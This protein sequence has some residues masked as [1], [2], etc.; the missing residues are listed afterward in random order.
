MKIERKRMDKGGWL[1][2]LE[3]AIAITLLIGV[4]VYMMST[5]APRKDISGDVYEKEKYILDMI[6]K[7]D[8][9][10][11]DI[12]ANKTDNI[13]FTI[14][15][16]IPVTWD[17]ETKICK[18]DDICEGSRRPVDKNVYSL[19]IVVSSNMTSY[20]PKKLRLFVWEK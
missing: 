14:Q 17:F 12:M 5:S 10:R 20:N 15:K 1:K 19:E 13:N 2:V 18:L 11:D 4:L 9:L 7:N 8:S 3:A 6:S 16:M